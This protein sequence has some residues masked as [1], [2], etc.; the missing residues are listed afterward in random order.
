MPRRGILLGPWQAVRWD[1]VMKDLLGD[2]RRWT[3]TERAAAVVIVA[4]IVIV[5][6]T[7]L[8]TSARSSSL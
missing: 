5:L 3:R 4:I 6:P 7:L 2:W 8:A 1:S